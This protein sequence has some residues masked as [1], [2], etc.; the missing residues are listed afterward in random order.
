MKT[1]L[2]L[3]LLAVSALSS[4]SASCA[5][6]AT[7]AA[8]VPVATGCPGR[9][10]GYG[11]DLL[12]RRVEAVL[13][14]EGFRVAAVGTMIRASRRFTGLEQG[15]IHLLDR[16]WPA[17]VRRDDHGVVAAYT[18]LRVQFGLTPDGESTCATLRLEPVGL[19]LSEAT[20]SALSKAMVDAVDAGLPL[21]RGH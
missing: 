12:G 15:R 14:H 11:A 21:Q 7:G 17:T 5:A 9:L 2:V 10:L 18:T 4:L 6:V 13:R 3:A 19:S 8:P 20:R 1:V 16:D